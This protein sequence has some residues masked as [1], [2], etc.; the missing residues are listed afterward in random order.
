MCKENYLSMSALGWSH[1]MIFL[2]M[3]S[4]EL[5]VQNQSL[6]LFKKYTSNQ[7]YDFTL[8]HQKT[9]E[10]F[11]RFPHRNKILAREPFEQEIKFLNMPGSSF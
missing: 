3:H 6:P 11:G 5:I 1:F 4:E 2:M 9:I 7:I 8:R 10:K